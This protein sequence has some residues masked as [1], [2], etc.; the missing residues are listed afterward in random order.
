MVSDS[1]LSSFTSAVPVTTGTAV[2][3]PGVAR[4]TSTR[5]SSTPSRPC[6]STVKS[7]LPASAS[8][9]SSI[10]ATRARFTNRMLAASATPSAIAS[11]VVN[12]CPAAPCTC[13]H[14]TRRRN[15]LRRAAAEGS[16]AP[17][18]GQPYRRGGAGLP[19]D[20][21]VPQFDR[22]VRPAPSIAPV[23]HHDDGH[24]V[25]PV[26]PGQQRQDRVP[27]LRI[28]TPSRLV[29]QDDRRFVYQRSRDCRTLLLTTRELAWAPGIAVRQADPAEHVF[30]DRSEPSSLNPG[31]LERPG[32]VVPD[33]QSGKEVE[34]LK[35]EADPAKTQITQ[36]LV[37]HPGKVLTL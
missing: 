22:A 37:G 29:R 15:A 20:P 36:C 27:R 14:A 9:E 28:E 6:A 2:T 34:T 23:G 18:A 35:D 3:T 12:N 11:P 32:D 26:E 30:D 10:E 1:P 16:M 8:I 4:T 33:R 31:E 25:L 13:A 5:P 17:S 24:T 21:S 19:R 7:A